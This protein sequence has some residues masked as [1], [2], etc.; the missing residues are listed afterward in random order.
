ME[1][2]D[3]IV[4]NTMN[5]SGTL[6]GLNFNNQI[7]NTTVSTAA[8]G[9]YSGNV[10]ISSNGSSVPSG[11]PYIYTTN[12]TNPTGLHVSGDSE[13]EGDIKV[14]GHSLLHLMKKMEERL[15]IL[16]EPDPAKLE[17]FAALKKAY[18]HY[19]TLERLIGE[20]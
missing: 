10:T 15:A 1:N 2:D 5:Y 9:Y 8:S 19:K 3:S 20:D 4:G 13:F 6:S 14:K 18:E 17:K 16:Q 7:F 12:T 11:S